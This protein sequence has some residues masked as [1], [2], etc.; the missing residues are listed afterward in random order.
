MG[1][2]AREQALADDQE[3]AGMDA[4]SKPLVRRPVAAEKTCASAVDD[5]ASRLRL[6]L[7]GR[8]AR[9]VRV[10]LQANVAKTTSRPNGQPFSVL[11]E[12]L[13][14]ADRDSVNAVAAA[15]YVTV[16]AAPLRARVH[17]SA[18][19]PRSSS[20]RSRPAMLQFATHVRISV[21]RAIA[22]AAQF[23][24]LDMAGR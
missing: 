14:S 7:A 1:N 18:N 13:D 16:R 20:M 4:A 17:F 3:R 22:P 10:R 12:K 2:R 21:S 23:I 15:L 6:S 19:A 8:T 24:S 11:T 5:P 9:N